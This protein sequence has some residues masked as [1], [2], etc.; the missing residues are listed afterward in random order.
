[1]THLDYWQAFYASR[2]SNAVPLKPSAFARWVHGELIPG[3]P[4]V[5]FG[6]GNARDSLWFVWRGHPVT[7]YDFAGSAVETAHDRARSQG[8]DASFSQLDLYD[9]ASAEVTAKTIAARYE[10]ASIYARFLLHAIEEPGRRNLFNLAAQALIHGGR[11]FLEFRTGLDRKTVHAFGEDHF[12]TYLDPDQVT[13][14]L[15]AAGARILHAEAGHG[16]AV[17]RSE[18]PHVARIVSHWS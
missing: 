12:R 14:E 2:V 1:M 6:F 9:G 4:I 17:Y 7:A 10:S 18:D 8:L 15:Q 16:L 11:L 5:E 13:A 3:A